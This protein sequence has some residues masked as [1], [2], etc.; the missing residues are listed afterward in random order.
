MV[1]T[2]SM[3][4]RYYDLEFS[5]IKFISRRKDRVLRKAYMDS[6]GFVE[7]QKEAAKLR[8]VTTIVP[9]MSMSGPIIK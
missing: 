3:E 1:A 8:N 9:Y 5:P 7:I 4:A 6:K 2:G